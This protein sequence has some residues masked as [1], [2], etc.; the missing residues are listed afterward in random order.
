[1]IR[2]LGWLRWWE[3][4]FL[5]ICNAKADTKVK[6]VVGKE[7]NFVQV[8]AKQ[9]SLGKSKVANLKLAQAYFGS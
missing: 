3:K 2:I 8:E 7:G 6:V 4:Q 1:M 9:L 5:A